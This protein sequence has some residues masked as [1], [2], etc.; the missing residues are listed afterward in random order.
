MAHNTSRGGYD[1]LVERLNKFPQGVP[2]SD[3]LFQIL[4]LLFSEEEAKLVSLLPIKPFSV[5]T[6]AKA[7]KKPQDETKEILD[8]LASRALLVDLERDGKTTYT[9]PP[10]MAG[11]FEFSMMRIGGKI[12]QKVLAELFYQYMNVEDDFIIALMSYETPIGRT[13][14]Q[15][16]QI[17]ETSVEV[18]GYERATE[19][20]KTAS[21]IGIGTCYCRH[22][23]EHVGKN[24]DAP[25]E[26]CMT[27][28]GT[29]SSLIK[30][31]YAKEVDAEECLRLL[32]VAKEHNLVQFGDNVQQEV[33][34]ICNCCGCCCEALV[35][36]RKRIPSQAIATSNFIC[37]IIT[38]H[39]TGCMKCVDVCPVEALRMVSKNDPHK[40]K[41]KVAV[42]TEEYC[43]GC[44]VC[45]NVCNFDAI[46]MLPRDKRVLT[47]V[48]MAHRVVLEAIEKNK[49]QNLFFDNQAHFSHRAMASILGVILKLSPIKQLLASE[50]VKSKYLVKLI[51]RNNQKIINSHVKN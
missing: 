2:P 34:F 6:A 4:R 27:F 37:D 45:K 51:E 26:I 49:L 25:M 38:E 36:A 17:K 11:F 50:Q 24:C 21:H 9:L 14:V 43:I 16:E 47:P 3:T 8:E 29:A 5:K 7:W 18:L 22:K 1:K 20:I 10:P 28:N 31:G 12:D 13:F 30:H 41:A 46:E 42:L 23:M 32:D 44:G 15:E 19:V 33:A 40:P 35:G 48:N 39:C